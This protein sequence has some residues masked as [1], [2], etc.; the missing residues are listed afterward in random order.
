MAYVSEDVHQ[1]LLSN[2]ACEQMGMISKNFPEVG[3]FQDN[4]EVSE[5]GVR[6][7]EDTDMILPD[8]DLDLTPCTPSPDGSCTCPRREQPP[9]PP[10]Y[11]A[12][13]ESDQLKQLI[14]KYYASSAFNKCTRQTL[15]KMQGDPLNQ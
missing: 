10:Q 2:E 9:P 8:E 13:M 12:G 7:T 4:A 5:V 11:P 14:L 1:L 3:E 15:P 6:Y